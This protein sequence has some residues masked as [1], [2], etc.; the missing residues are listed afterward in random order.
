MNTQATYP[1]RAAAPLKLLAPWWRVFGRDTAIKEVHGILESAEGD[2][3]AARNIFEAEYTLH[4]DTKTKLDLITSILGATNQEHPKYL[5]FRKLFRE[6]FLRFANEENL[7]DREAEAVLRMQAVEE[8]LRLLGRVPLFREKTIVAVA[9][10]FNSGKSTLI[11]SFFDPQFK[12]TLPIAMEPVTAIPTYI[13]HNTETALIGFPAHGGAVKIV[14]EVFAKMRHEFLKA[15]GFDLRRILPFIVLE[16]AWCKPWESLCFIDTPGYNPAKGGG[17]TAADDFT[18]AE[19]L[20][21]ADALLWVLGIDA[22]GE[23]CSDDLEY[24]RSYGAELPLAVVVNKAEFTPPEP[25][26]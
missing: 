5:R 24:L 19:A 23:I 17:T 2:V 26:A 14:P 22:N 7:Y 12:V 13:A 18:T 11:S 1:Q 25:G 21:Q 9:G 15:L 6:D 20:R 10:G 3:Q 16:T 8:E 4:Q